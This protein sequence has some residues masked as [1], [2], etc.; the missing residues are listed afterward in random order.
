MERITIYPD[1]E[2]KELLKKQAEEE[3]R[4]LNQQIIFILKNQKGGSK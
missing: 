2:F 3:N 4:S 1:K